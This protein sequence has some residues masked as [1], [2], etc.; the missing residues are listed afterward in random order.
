MQDQTILI[1]LDALV[2]TRLPVLSSL[3]PEGAATIMKNG[4]WD[5]QRDDFDEMSGGLI[6]LAAYKAAYAARDKETLKGAI[7]TTLLH[8]V[9]PMTQELQRRQASKIEIGEIHLLVNIWPYKLEDYEVE[10]YL[11]VIRHYVALS[12]KVNAVNA[13]IEDLTPQALD[14]LADIY[15][16]Y[17]YDEWMTTH[18]EELR[19]NPLPMMT[20]LTPAIMHNPEK[21]SK[22]ELTDMKTGM[23]FNPFKLHQDVMSEFIG[24][25]FHPAFVFSMVH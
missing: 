3:S 4:Y 25:E 19:T 16:T 22:E 7:L 14:K 12:C 10:E 11:N 6:D 8:L 2:D 21:L 9:G 20:I 13:S 17:N 15:M 18:G 24:I 5:R 1:D 23:E